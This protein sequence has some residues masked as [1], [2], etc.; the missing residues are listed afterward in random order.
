MAAGRDAL[1]FCVGGPHGLGERVLRRANQ[2]LS[3]SA[4]TM[5]HELALTVLLEQ[6][7]RGL[8]ILR[9]EKYHK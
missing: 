6:L 7:Y 4:M 9:G 8:T 3:L 2:R 5:A 1:V